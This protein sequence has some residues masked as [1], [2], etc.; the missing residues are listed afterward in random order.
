MD[1]TDAGATGLGAITL[2]QFVFGR[3]PCLY[4]G[5]FLQDALLHA[6]TF[7]LKFSGQRRTH[8]SSSFAV[9]HY[10]GERINSGAN[11]D[12]NRLR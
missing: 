7:G 6:A 1:W 10:K 9:F 11:A 12:S 5:M 3:L 4:D 8:S 2:P